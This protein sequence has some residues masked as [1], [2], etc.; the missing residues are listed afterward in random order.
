MLL[1][2]IARGEASEAITRINQLSNGS[3]DWMVLVSGMGDASS[4]CN[5]QVAD[6]GINHLSPMKEKQY[7]IWLFNVA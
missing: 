2:E 3:P 7:V 6:Q 4:D 1:A 5:A